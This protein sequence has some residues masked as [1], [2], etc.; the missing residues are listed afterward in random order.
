M[1]GAAAAP[2]E[3]PL[4]TQAPSSETKG[5]EELQTRPLESFL[6]FTGGEGLVPGKPGF[7]GALS[8]RIA[9]EAK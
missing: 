2:R 1:T 6:V 4:D 9:G 5:S 8:L 7:Q 3:T